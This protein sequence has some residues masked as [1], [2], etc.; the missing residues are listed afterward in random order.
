VKNYTGDRLNFGMA[1]EKAKQEKINVKIVI[2]EDDCALPVGKGITGGRGVAGTVFVHKVAGAAAAAGLSLDE[3]HAEASAAAKLIGSLGIALTT[4]TVPGA[5]T[6]QRLADPSVFEVGMGIHGEPGREQAKLPETGAADLAA[7]LM[8]EGIL[9]SHAGFHFTLTTLPPRLDVVKGDRVAVLLNNL[10]GLPAIEMLVVVRRVM[11]NLRG[12]GIHPVRVYVGPYMTALEMAG[13]SL[14]LFKIKDDAVLARV[15]AATTAPAWNASPAITDT[16]G[17]EAQCIPYSAESLNGT[18][19]GGFPSLAAV[20][21][22]RAVCRRI[23]EIEPKLTEFDAVCGDG[24]CGIVMQAGAR[25]VLSDLEPETEADAKEVETKAATGT[26]GGALA[27]ETG[28]GT[29][30]VRHTGAV[31]SKCATDSAYLC[32]Q[33]ADSISASMGGTSGAILEIFFRAA[34]TSLSDKVVQYPMPLADDRMC[35]YFFALFIY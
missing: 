15:D 8:C 1:M 16:T 27:A 5:P 4:C 7:D 32:H 11:L 29:G 2:V 18:V 13:V 9:G 23:I 20:V 31:A 24:D 34:A 19:T 33:V 30:A 10:G 14:S 17:D 26:E 35:A 22:A 6:S 21:V 3:V 28:T 25:R 12:R